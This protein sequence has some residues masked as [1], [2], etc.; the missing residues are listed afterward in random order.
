MLPLFIGLLLV[1]G[2]FGFFL[3]DMERKRRR[4]AE[5]IDRVEPLVDRDLR[6][7]VRNLRGLNNSLFYA[8]HLQEDLEGVVRATEAQH[9]LPPPAG[10]GRF[11]LRSGRR[12][13]DLAQRIAVLEASGDRGATTASPEPQAPA[14]EDDAG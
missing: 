4:L 12:L 8:Y 1:V 3:A 6:L 2:L 5:L 10:S 14:D 11:S 7:H 9:G 13:D